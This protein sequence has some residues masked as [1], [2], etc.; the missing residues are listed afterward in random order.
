MT[1]VTLK[2]NQ[3]WGRRSGSIKEPHGKCFQQ[4]QW[5]SGASHSSR[6]PKCSLVN[7]NKKW[8]K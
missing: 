4:Q 6:P 2:T 1:A 3:F 8:F 5:A 7:I